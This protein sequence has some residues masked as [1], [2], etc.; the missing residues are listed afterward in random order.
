M[1]P[2][3]RT[4]KLQN[5]HANTISDPN[6]PRNMWWMA[7]RSEDVTRTPLG[8]WMLDEPIVL[9]RKEDGQAVAL[10]DRCPH[11][12][13]PLSQGKTVGDEIA[14][15]YHGLRFDDKGACSHIP[16]Q[17]HIP[18]KACVKSYPV[19]EAGPTVWIWMGDPRRADPSTVPDLSWLTE[20]KWSWT[21]STVE[22]NANYRLLRE[23]VLDLTHIPH[24]HAN[25]IGANDWTVPP[26]VTVSE[27]GH[28]TY[29]QD[30]A[31]GPLAP[32]YL[33]ATGID[34]Q[35]PIARST[36]GT[37]FTPAFHQAWVRLTDPHPELG[38][39]AEWLFTVCHITTPASPTRFV[40]RWY[41]GY[42]I[43]LSD[44]YLAIMK[45]HVT[46]GYNEDKVILE[47]IQSSVMRDPRGM[48]YPEILLQA[49][50][51]A[52]QFRRKL[53]AQLA[54]ERG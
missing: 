20:P 12:W 53:D 18:A 23:N 26:R 1:N 9:Y 41:M 36:R 52:L 51:A 44:E 38:K 48:H 15:P 4:T 27:Q 7:A 19:V 28:V 30:F 35:R 6:Y 25:S 5:P 2:T 24:V 8:I 40:Y 43:D 45:T 3:D 37:S 34:P 22:V 21:S 10:D 46:A 33:G 39:R 32:A 47:A 42:D 16:S 29:E 17:T 11:R 54:A 50:Q 49:D 31:A 14:C 13:A